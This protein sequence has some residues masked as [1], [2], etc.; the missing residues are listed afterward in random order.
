MIFLIPPSSLSHANDIF[1]NKLSKLEPN[2][3]QLSS[4]V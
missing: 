3:I 1:D 4:V 2:D